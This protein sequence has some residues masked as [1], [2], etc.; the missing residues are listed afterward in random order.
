MNNDIKRR[1]DELNVLVRKAALTVHPSGRLSL[2]A[3][4]AKVH[5]GTIRTA[6]KKANFTVGLAS[7][8]EA[9][10]GRDVLKRE[11]LCPEINKN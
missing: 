2:L 3:D 4:K 7:A 9:A 6:I 5:V 10:V 8:L 11:E 1:S